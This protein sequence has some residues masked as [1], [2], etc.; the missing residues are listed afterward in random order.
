LGNGVS[1][2]NRSLRDAGNA[3]RIR[4]WNEVP[5]NDGCA[6]QQRGIQGTASTLLTRDEL[7][8]RK[9]RIAPENEFCSWDSFGKFICFF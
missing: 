2:P 6:A 9:K 3:R 4:S 8:L 5:W 1:L 7:S